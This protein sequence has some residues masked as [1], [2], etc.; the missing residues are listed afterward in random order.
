MFELQ[1]FNKRDPV[2]FRSMQLFDLGHPEGPRGTP[3]GNRKLKVRI[4]VFFLKV[5]STKI[6]FPGSLNI[7]R[8]LVVLHKT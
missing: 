7:A 6:L 8:N 4:W 3:Q 2:T 1:I 5:T